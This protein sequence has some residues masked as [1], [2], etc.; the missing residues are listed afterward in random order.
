M[1]KK[2][3]DNP[4]VGVLGGGQLGRMLALA[5][6][7]WDGKLLV[8]DRR[9]CPAEGV[10]CELVEGDF[11][12]EED[13]LGFGKKVD[14][15]TIEIEHVHTG[16][17]RKLQ[18]EGVQVHPSP[19][20]LDIIA[21]KG[22]Q[23]LFYREKGFPTSPF[24]LYDGPEDILQAVRQGALSL[25]FVQKARKGGYDGKGVLVVHQQEQLEQLL[26]LPS[27]VEALVDIELE[28]AVIAARNP[29]GEV[30]TY[31]PVEQHF[32]PEANLLDKLI[33]PSTAPSEYLAKARSLAEQLI[34]AL[35]ICGLLAVEFF[36]TSHG[37]LLINEAAPRPHNSG[38]HTIEACPC[39]QFEQHLRAILDLPL[40]DTRLLAPAIT[41]NILGPENHYGP[42]SWQHYKHL[43]E[44]PGTH[45]H[46][47]GKKE[48][49]PFRKMGHVTE[50][51][52]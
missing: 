47:Y 11:R 12:S 21:D 32:L 26:P 37:E 35:D 28:L 10:A 34:R 20:A 7:K 3:K 2:R 19:D 48:S 17:L 50:M 1:Q 39:S 43:L 8:L 18:E 41:R 4:V 40:G 52:G 31:D 23:K 33:A 51:L 29:S 5:F 45:L 24:K 16:A 22:L 25:P 13:V 15:L 30:R 46:L 49:R 42:L 9:G 38:H 14:V 6:A 44:K 27:V 36:L